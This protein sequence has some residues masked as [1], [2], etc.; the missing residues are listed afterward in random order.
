MLRKVDNKKKEL[1]WANI[2]KLLLLLPVKSKILF[3]VC[4][5]QIAWASSTSLA[6]QN[7]WSV[8]TS[9]TTLTGEERFGG[10]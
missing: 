4:M 9:S 7:G 10:S 3:S 2:L 6:S 5:L 8:L 1:D